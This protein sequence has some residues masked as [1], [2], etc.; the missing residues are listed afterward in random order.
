MDYRQLYATLRQRKLVQTLVVY[1]GASWG[2]L[3]VLGFFVSTYG[4]SRSIIDAALLVLGCGLVGALTIAWFHGEKGR[5]RVT[6]LELVVLFLVAL[7]AVTGGWGL[8][9][10]TVESAAADA[11]APL[12]EGRLAVLPFENRTGDGSLAWLQRGLA[13]MLATDLGQLPKLRVVSG[14][15]VY[16][17]LKQE[18]VA[19][20]AIVSD[21]MAVRV[22]KKASAAHLVRGFV[23]RSGGRLRLDV[24]LVSAASGVQAASAH[25]DGPDLFLLVDSVAAQ[26]AAR[27]KDVT[28]GAAAP[29]VT[30]AAVATGNLEAYREY[31]AGLEAE[32]QSRM[33]DAL[34]HYRRAVELDSTFAQA[35]TKLALVEM[36]TGLAQ[37]AGDHL[38]AA[39]R[40]LTRAPERERLFV[41]AVLAMV[42]RDTPG[43]ETKLE[44]LTRGY[45]DDKDAWTYLVGLYRNDPARADRV[46]PSLR[47]V[48][49]LDPYY[50]PAYNQLAYTYAGKKQFAQA[51]SFAR[52]YVELSPREPNPLDTRGEVLEMA[53]RY[54]EARQQY[55]AALALRPD[56]TI[57]MEHLARNAVH[58]RRFDELRADLEPFTRQASPIVR[59]SAL[60]QI[61]ASYS[62][63]GRVEDAAAAYQRAYDAAPASEPQLRIAALSGMAGEWTMLGQYARVVEALKSVKT[64]TTAGF[65]VYLAALGELGRFEE[66]RTARDAMTDFA[67]RPGMAIFAGG[68]PRLID[69]YMAYYQHDWASAVEAFADV[70]RQNRVE[71]TRMADRREVLALIELGRAREALP[72]VA[73]P[74][75]PRVPDTP[76]MMYLRGRVQEALGNR[77]AAVAAY[78]QVMAFWG[79]GIR[80]FPNYRD[81]PQ[82]LAKL[83]G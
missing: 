37:Q 67:A 14:E 3:Q 36:N 19:E 4:W 21:F 51:D 20:A 12:A 74:T 5:Q 80:R 48:L 31:Q 22:A 32:R 54:A 8:G 24:Q 10:R 56:F 1:A 79:P 6:R 57:A 49:R 28:G 65:Y 35:L 58:T 69:G 17:L 78:R 41:E 44:A 60:S 34:P 13:D 55:L 7:V 46:E 66:M 23:Y 81:V 2:I 82:R 83:G 39:Q 52:R 70:K 30:L 61:A 64:P 73:V 29:A 76:G 27:L 25:A 26:L 43:A 68:L 15:R 59:V 72:M 77:A 71:A 9:R 33:R 40:H 45:P 11:E 53:G 50:A 47:Q 38:L 16:D 42:R 62:W 75:D 63:Q 18:G